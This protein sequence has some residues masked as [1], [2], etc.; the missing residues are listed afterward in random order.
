MNQI[1]EISVLE[2]VKGN[3]GISAVEK[4]LTEFEAHEAKEEKSVEEYRKAL[5]GMT[6]PATRFIMQMI[7]SDEERHRAVTRAMAATLEGS[8]NRTKPVASLEGAPDDTELNRKLSDVTEEFIELETAGLREYKRLLNES[9][10]YI[11]TA[12]SKF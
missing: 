8:L 6:D 9:S 5:A 12:C 4:L 10:G 2:F 1:H 7:V 3:Q 11:I